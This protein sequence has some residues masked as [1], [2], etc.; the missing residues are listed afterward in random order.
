MD[1]RSRAACGSL[2]AL[3]SSC[4]ILGAPRHV[5]AVTSTTR[6]APRPTGR[7]TVTTVD[8][9]A[10][11]T[12]PFRAV[13][14]TASG[15]AAPPKVRDSEGELV[16]TL[17]RGKYRVVVFHGLEW[18]A[19]EREIDIDGTE[20]HLTFGLRHVVDPSGWASTDLHVH[21]R[22]SF[23]SL[24]TFES[25][26]RSLTALGVESAVA[27]DHDAVSAPV[28]K[29]SLG[30]IGGVEITRKFGHLNAFPYT[31]A[32]PPKR[33]RKLQEITSFVREQA[34][35]ALLQVNHP[36]LRGMGLFTLLGITT[37]KESTLAR[38]PREVKH[39]EV[40][41]GHD[42]RVSTVR[43]MVDEWLRL[44]Q[45]GR[46]LWATGG[47]DVHK[48]TKPTPGFPRTYVQCLPTPS[49]AT[50]ATPIWVRTMLAAGRAFVTSGP[51]VELTQ[52][53]RGPGSA[54][55]V[56]EGRALFHVKVQAAPFVSADELVVLVGGREITKRD[57]PKRKLTLDAAGTL[58]EARKAASLFDGDIEVPVAADAKTLVVLVRGCQSLRTLLP[59]LE[60]EPIAFSNPLVIGPTP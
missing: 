2:L 20:Q 39:L 49:R 9:D 40:F 18:T 37:D 48:T 21:A 23:D 32:P 60:M 41:N 12:I 30:W 50:C 36:R 53:G 45:A 42:T 51:F 22:N 46:P 28:A 5:G 44:W 58:D 52:D 6:I 17:P 27:S 55:V 13:F 54:L 35:E 29:G 57:L 43:A 38:L 3:A 25:R 4:A 34:P 16:L 59:T 19:D 31:V 11:T 24:V 47:S 8:R 33:L 7:L 15:R 56:K 1:R 26:E 10:G 14:L